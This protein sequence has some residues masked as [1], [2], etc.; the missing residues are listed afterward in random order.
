[1]DNFKLIS[2]DKLDENFV[3]LIGQDWM[4]ITAGN[5]ND[6]NTM[7]AAWGGMGFLWNK[8]VCFTFIRPQRHT[9]KYSE[10]NDDFTLSFFMPEKRDLLKLLGT[11]SGKDIDK[12]NIEGLTGIKCGNTVAFKEAAIV[13]ECTKV[14][15]DLI[16][17]ENMIDKD[18][19]KHY[20]KNDFHKMYIGEVKNCFVNELLLD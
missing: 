5:T 15:E 1:M 4:L 14:Y 10:A 2:I 13:I 3:E 6:Y 19:I 7:T 17:P 12:M 9:Y 20:P 16:K 8:A 11:K 18:I